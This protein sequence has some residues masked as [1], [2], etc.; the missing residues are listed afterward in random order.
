MSLAVELDEPV[1]ERIFAFASA[2]ASASVASVDWRRCPDYRTLKACA[3][4]CPP[5]RYP[6][7]SVLAKH[8]RIASPQA[9]GAIRTR[10]AKRRLAEHTTL[11]LEAVYQFGSDAYWLLDRFPRLEAFRI[12]YDPQRGLDGQA[13]RDAEWLTWD[14]LRHPSLAGESRQSM[15]TGKPSAEIP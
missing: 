3:L 4:V 1:L 5:W 2:P 15:K 12:D 7:Q 11:V 13:H 9:M 8:V 14:I 10:E 6:A